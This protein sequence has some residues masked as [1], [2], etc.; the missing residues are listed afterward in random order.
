MKKRKI[1][2]SMIK[3]SVVHSYTQTEIILGDHAC[4]TD[5]PYYPNSPQTMRSFTL[6]D[7]SLPHGGGK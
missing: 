4:Q 1:D 7:L 2:S 5:L 3:R 6:V